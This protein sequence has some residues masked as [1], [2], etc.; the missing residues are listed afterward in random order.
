MLIQSDKLGTSIAGSLRVLA[1]SLR[2]KR[3]QQAEE[4][5]HKTQVKLV[6]PLVLLGFPELMVILVG[7]A[8]INLI[9]TLTEMARSM[10]MASLCVAR[11]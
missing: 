4:A 1:D 10:S 9:K 7:P 8:M 11:N 5:A 3:R 6:F 2:V